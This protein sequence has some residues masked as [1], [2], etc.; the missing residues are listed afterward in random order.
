MNQHTVVSAQVAEHQ[1]TQWRHISS[2]G[3]TI[4]YIRAQLA[5]Q[6][7]RWNISA[8]GQWVHQVGGTWL[9]NRQFSLPGP[10]VL[11]DYFVSI[12]LIKFSSIQTKLTSFAK[13][14]DRDLSEWNQQE[15]TYKNQI[16][17]RR[18]SE[19]LPYKLRRESNVVLAKWAL[20]I[21][22]VTMS[23]QAWESQS[24]RRVSALF[25]IK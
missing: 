14:R 7:T 24:V 13:S 22:Y 19:A 5:H 25:Q 9:I 15:S 20:T 3:G 12:K 8:Q 18:L 23:S 11:I 10:L 17:N 6:F 2:H 21:N 16:S 4:N 1:C